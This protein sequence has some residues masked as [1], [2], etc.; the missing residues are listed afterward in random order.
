VG[1]DGVA[2]G[3][4]QVASS[5]G[6]VTLARRDSVVRRVVPAQLACRIG[7][8]ARAGAA[9]AAKTAATANAARHVVSVPISDAAGRLAT[10]AMKIPELTT[11]IAVPR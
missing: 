11:A 6:P 5:A 7:A 3:S 2:A 9:I 8:R 4:G 1:T 10:V